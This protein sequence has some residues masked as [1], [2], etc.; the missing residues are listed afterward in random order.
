MH[1][2]TDRLILRPFCE[3][4]FA[5]LRALVADPRILQYRSRTSITEDETRALLAQACQALTE[6]SPPLYAFAILLRQKPGKAF[7]IDFQGAP[8]MKIDP[9]ELPR[10]PD[11]VVK[12]KQK[13]G[14]NVELVTKQI[15][16]K[17]ELNVA[18][19]IRII[20]VDRNSVGERI[21]LRAGDVILQ[22]GRFR[23]STLDDFGYILDRIQPGAQV[24]IG[25]MRDG[26][27]IQGRF[28]YQP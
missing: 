3:D 6:P 18:D 8:A 14:I 23:V 13:L 10:Q 20:S 1:L 5:A 21:G 9:K 11:A 27:I 26:Q 2:I 4:D 7:N 24:F 17:N 12:A 22:I 19:G 25:V 28:V 15:A 16:E